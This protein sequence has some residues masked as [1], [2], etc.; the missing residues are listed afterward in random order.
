MRNFAHRGIHPVGCLACLPFYCARLQWVGWLAGLKTAENG[1]FFW[2]LLLKEK[3]L[4]VLK[5]LNN[6]RFRVSF[7]ETSSV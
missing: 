5:P 3:E 1:A 6:E 7:P 2:A 4:H